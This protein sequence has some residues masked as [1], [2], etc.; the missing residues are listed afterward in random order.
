MDDIL[1]ITDFVDEENPFKNPLRE[2]SLTT[3]AIPIAPLG[4]S[5]FKQNKSIKRKKKKKAKSY[6]ADPVTGKPK[7]GEVLY[8]GLED[9]EHLEEAEE[10]KTRRP[11]RSKRERE[12][13]RKK[14]AAKGLRPRR[15]WATRNL[16]K[17]FQTGGIEYLKGVDPKSEF[18]TLNRRIQ[19]DPTLRS[20]KTELMKIIGVLRPIIPSGECLLLRQYARFIYLP[21]SAK[22]LNDWEAGGLSM[23]Q[24]PAGWWGIRNWRRDISD[25]D[26][27]QRSYVNQI[28]FK[29][30]QRVRTI[31]DEHNAICENNFCRDLGHAQFLINGYCGGF[32][33]D[34]GEFWSLGDAVKEVAE[35]KDQDFA[36]FSKRK[37]GKVRPEAPPEDIETMKRARQIKKE[38]GVVARLREVDPFKDLAASWRQFYGMEESLDPL[39]ISKMI[40]DPDDTDL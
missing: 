40:E 39:K 8:S 32:K 30:L 35:E 13:A 28:Y 9:E 4:D 17:I 29:Y 24:P 15:E 12:N 36:I 16:P 33:I 25:L 37:R 18:I 23:R 21:S 14:Q 27:Y 19:G 20:A 2:M 3:G 7:N 34:T 6:K 10:E 22:A 5:G 38:R 31:Y 1:K 11:I 26:R